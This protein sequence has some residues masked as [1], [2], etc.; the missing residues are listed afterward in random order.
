MDALRARSGPA[1]LSSRQGGLTLIE[2]LV[3]LAMLG[4]VVFAVLPEVSNWMRNLAVRNVGESLKGGLE[5]ARLEALRRNG[6]VSFWLVSDA[7]EI[8]L[9]NS[10]QIS[11]EGSSWVVS[12]QDPSGKCASAASQDDGAVVIEKWASSD[13]GRAVL[14]EALDA[15]GVGANRVTFTSLG[16]LST[17]N[18]SA[19]RIVIKH[20]EGDARDLRIDINPGGSV[21]LC[22]PNVAANDPRRC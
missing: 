15:N 16:Q 19:A 18:V 11:S 13:G 7:S 10:C 21:R 3:A 6:S 17:A 4:M 9:T 20:S 1:L 5:R 22:D 14:V 12:G 2:L 8:G